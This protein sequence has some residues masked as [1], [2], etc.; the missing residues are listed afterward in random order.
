MLSDAQKRILKIDFSETQCHDFRMLKESRVVI[1][2]G[3][4]ADSGY[5]GAQKIYSVALPHK[6]SK[7]HVLT[8]EE[9]AFNHQLSK[10][11]IRIENIF[12]VL[13]VFKILGTRYRN[14]RKRLNLRF[15]LI[16][17][18]YNFELEI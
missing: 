12:S 17:A 18:I 13:K 10:R 3:F 16:A 1:P 2:C 6:K 4:L 11:R 8:E 9:K 5:Q 14:H 15:N 7:Y